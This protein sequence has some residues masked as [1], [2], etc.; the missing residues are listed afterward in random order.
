MKVVDNLISP[1]SVWPERRQ[2]VEG[3]G[4]RF[5]GAGGRS[6]S[7][8]PHLVTQADGSADD[9]RGAGGRRPT[10]LPGWPAQLP[11]EVPL[12]PRMRLDHALPPLQPQRL[13]FLIS[14]G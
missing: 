1:S 8:P 9:R 13:H 12:V 3:E 7:H 14:Y 4:D 10:R 2:R 11:G 5:V 6:L